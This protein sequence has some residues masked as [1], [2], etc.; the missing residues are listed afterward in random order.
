LQNVSTPIAQVKMKSSALARVQEAYDMLAKTTRGDFGSLSA[1]DTLSRLAEKDNEALLA[2]AGFYL[3]YVSPETGGDAV[4][5]FHLD[6]GARLERINFLANPSANGLKQSAGLMVNYLYDL[7][8]VEESHEAF[9]NGNVV[10]S[11]AVK[12]LM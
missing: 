2:L 7:K 11:R 9:V 12:S 4:A 6:N 5:R 3:A 10:H 1:L 8:R